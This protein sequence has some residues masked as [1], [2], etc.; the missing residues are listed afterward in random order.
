[1]TGSGMPPSVQVAQYELDL[2]VDHA[3][4]TFKGTVSAEL[5][6]APDRVEF[7]ALDLDVHA[8]TVNGAPVP[9]Q[10]D[11]E[12]QKLAVSLPWAGSVRVTVAYSGKAQRD[13]LTGLYVSSFGG[14]TLLTTM[15]EPASCRRLLPC[16]DQPDQKAVFRLRLTTDADLTVVFNSDVQSSSREGSKRT[17]VFEP[18]PRM[19]TYLLYLGIGRFE[20]KEANHGKLRVIA[21]TAP[22]KTSLAGRP[23]AMAGPLLDAYAEYYGIPYPLPKLH[24]V[25]VPDLWAGGM[26]NW[27]AIVIPELGLLWDD[28]TSPAVVRWAVETLSHEI[29]HQWFGNLVT[30][31]TW[32]D[33]WLNE[34]FATFVAYTMEER[35]RLRDD[36]W[37]E[38]LIRT[39]PG[40]FTDSYS[41]THPVQ[42]RI[43]DPSE[44][45]QSTDDIT[46]YK[47]ANV[48]RM[49]ETYLGESTFR[50]GVAAYLKRFAYRN[51]RSDDLWAALEEASHE[52]VQRVMRDWVDRPGIPMVRVH[53][54][55]SRLTLTQ[56]RFTF[57]G[58]A[59]PELPWPIPMRVRDDGETRRLLFDR[60]SLELTVR[61]PESYQLNPG[62]TA[63]LRIWYEPAERARRIARLAA[64]DPFDRWAFLNDAFAFVL[65]GD[66]PLADYLAAVDQARRATDYPSVE[67]V[68]GSLR[69][70]LRVLREHRP[71][72]EAAAGFLRAQFE[73]LGPAR[74]TGETDTD[75]VLRQD[76]ASGLV[77][78]DPS[79]AQSLAGSFDS[80][81]SLDAA[82]RP[83]AVLAFARAGGPSALDRLYE[84]VR[85]A[86]RQDDAERA[87]F[88]M[89]M[90][91]TEELL[92][93]AVARCMEP[94][95]RTSLIQSI[96]GSVISSRE[97]RGPAWQWLQAN[98][99]EFER[100]AQGSWML[101]NLFEH[102]I[103]LIGVE[104]GDEVRR[105]FAEERFPEGSNGIKKG[106]ELLDVAEALRT[107]VA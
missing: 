88:A 95:I 32:D 15:M 36:P 82:I 26:E 68:A 17:W 4:E 20:A 52:P 58:G 27:G 102:A 23:L 71:V 64:L 66:Y 14:S 50:S 28:S 77:R 3:Q 65:S 93:R 34:S 75:A 83:A 106:L 63:F 96:V 51:A 1:M 100:R 10:V 74:R 9:F 85:S 31:Q 13:L 89:E 42:M 46:Y 11:L 57:R 104:R 21:A 38:F 43:Q 73:R 29:A 91:P 25:A 35:L 84:R 54:D 16:F 69:F 40:Y 18:T 94:G 101:S 19:A 99:R 7:D 60:E 107:R 87:A 5:T 59:A 8:V 33:L 44:I 72:E 53:R 76:I 97:G 6:D 92:R 62:R 81:D 49:L 105:F 22:G 39:S 37:A 90:L 70:L 78:A 47:G 55:G 12:R 30:M 67:D 86:P 41:S 61:T 48:V 24:L 56:Q 103:P 80:I 45:S 2:Y 98:L 79:F